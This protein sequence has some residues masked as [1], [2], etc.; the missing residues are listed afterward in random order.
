MKTSTISIVFTNKPFLNPGDIIIAKNY[1]CE[2]N[3]LLKRS[4]NQLKL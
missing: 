3:L 1:L 2:Q 4:R